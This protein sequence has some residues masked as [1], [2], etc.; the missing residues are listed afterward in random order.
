MSTGT[1]LKIGAV[2]AL[3]FLIAGSAF[4]GWVIGRNQAADQVS[5][6]RQRLAADTLTPAPK[7]NCGVDVE[8]LQGRAPDKAPPAEAGV[9]LGDGALRSPTYLHLREMLTTR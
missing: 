8:L 9:A 5:E 1:W 6:L 2:A 4:A 3:W 7:Q